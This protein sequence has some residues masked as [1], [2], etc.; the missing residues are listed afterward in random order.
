MLQ[1]RLDT[2]YLQYIYPHLR[3]S[4]DTWGVGHAKSAP[5]ATSGRGAS[6]VGSRSNMSVTNRGT[7]VSNS[8]ETHS[9]HNSMDGMNKWPRV[10]AMPPTCCENIATPRVS[11]GKRRVDVDSQTGSLSKPS[12]LDGVMFDRGLKAHW[13]HHANSPVPQNRGGF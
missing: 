12:L 6:Y 9:V 8:S 1:M 3:C 11:N 10:H 2:E 13:V 4:V 5:T 7:S